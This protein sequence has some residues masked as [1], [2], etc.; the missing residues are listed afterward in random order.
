MV[1]AVA[2][3]VTVEVTGLVPVTPLPVLAPPQP[4]ANWSPMQAMASKRVCFRRRFLEKTAMNI[5]ASVIPPE[6][7]KELVRRRAAWPLVET[8]T[9]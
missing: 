1:P 5:S 7:R 2:T 3:I 9:T 8:V 6:S 4:T